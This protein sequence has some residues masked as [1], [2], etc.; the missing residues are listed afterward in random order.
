M[1]IL[2]LYHIGTPRLDGVL[3]GVRLSG[4]KA[5]GGKTVIEYDSMTYHCVPIA[6]N[7][8]EHTSDIGSPSV[9]FNI[10]LPQRYGVLNIADKIN[11]EVTEGATVVRT[12]VLIEGGPKQTLLRQERY[13]MGRI[14]TRSNTLIETELIVERESWKTIALADRPGKC[15]WKYRGKG[16]GYK[17]RP[18]ADKNDKLTSEF[19]KDDCSLTIRGCEFRFPN[20]NLPFGNMPES[21]RNNQGGNQ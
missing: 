5:T 6:I 17:G 21:V 8:I 19:L 18:I 2:F 20:G 14:K 9:N 11:E 7:N 1:E 4:S 10:T 15:H 12:I 3:E 16:C 13:K